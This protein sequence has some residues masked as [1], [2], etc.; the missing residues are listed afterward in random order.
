[1]PKGSS[2]HFWRM[3]TAKAM[4]LPEPV[5][6]PPM[7]SLPLRISGMQCFWM[8]VGRLIAMAPREATSHGLTLR[9][10]KVVWASVGARTFPWLIA[11]AVVLAR[12]VGW[13]RAVREG[14]A[15]LGTK[16]SPSSMG[17]TLLRFR[18]ACESRDSDSDA[19]ELLSASDLL[20]W[21]SETPGELDPEWPDSRLIVRDAAMRRDIR[22]GAVVIGGQTDQ[23]HGNCSLGGILARVREPR[24]FPH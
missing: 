19:E 14:T 12:V 17:E 5:R 8:P 9:A 23:T 13:P 1:M 10:A 15:S 16:G 22:R 21:D 20:E 18:A 3:G 24:F 4:V 11:L 6:L 7:Q 2:A